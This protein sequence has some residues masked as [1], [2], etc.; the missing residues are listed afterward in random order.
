[1]A[2]MNDVEASVALD[3]DRRAGRLAGLVLAASMAALRKSM[4]TILRRKSE[5]G[6][7]GLEGELWFIEVPSRL[8]RF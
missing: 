5:A 1:M 6:V 2:G 4:E 7:G 8:S 3:E